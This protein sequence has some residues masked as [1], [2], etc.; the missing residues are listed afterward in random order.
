MKRIECTRLLHSELEFYMFLFQHIMICS[1]MLHGSHSS[2]SGER[3]AMDNPSDDVPIPR[4]GAFLFD[5]L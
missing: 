4:S 1:F 3:S 5:N 2:R